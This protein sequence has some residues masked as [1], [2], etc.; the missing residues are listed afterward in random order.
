MAKHEYALVT[1]ASSG[2]GMDFAK[3]LGKLGYSLVLVARRKEQLEQLKSEILSV[4]NDLTI[5]VIAFDLA[6]I[7]ASKMLFDEVKRL[8]I[9]VHILINNAGFGVYGNFLDATIEKTNKMLQLNMITLTELTYYF[10]LEMKKNNFGYIL[11][12]ASLGAYQPSPYFAAYAATKAYVMLF[13]E[14]LDF[15]LKGTQVSVTTL[16]PGA[17]KTG[18]FDVAQNKLSGFVE[19]SLMTSEE[20]ARIG[21]DAMFKRKRSSIPGWINKLSAIASQ[22]TPRKIATWSAANLMK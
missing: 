5:H 9:A 12:V 2:I 1:G 7:D 14:A 3:I 16:Y 22:L 18:F 21:V 6:Q 20:V 13:S 17:T 11:Q 4:N 19:K 10:G 15:E 8:N